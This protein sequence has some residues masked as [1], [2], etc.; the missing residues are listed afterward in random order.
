VGD[1]DREKQRNRWYEKPKPPR[2]ESSSVHESVDDGSTD[3][4]VVLD[5]AGSIREISPS[6]THL[7]AHRRGQ[8]LATSFWEML[9]PDDA[10]AVQSLLGAVTEMAEEP[11]KSTCD[12][13]EPMAA[14]EVSRR[15]PEL[16]QG[17]T[18]SP[19]WLW[20]PTT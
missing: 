18:T 17:Q 9:H 19:W 15:W 5:G 4:L 13:V 20:K 10:A 12:C 14:G 2:P 11:R 3:L 6:V 8:L 16:C 1:D 7:L